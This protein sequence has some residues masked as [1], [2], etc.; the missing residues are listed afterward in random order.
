MKHTFHLI[1]PLCENQMRYPK[2]W[3]TNDLSSME[4]N[5]FLL[6]I[7]GGW[8]HAQIIKQ[9]PLK[10][11]LEPHSI[12]SSCHWVGDK[13]SLPDE[14][15][16]PP[17]LPQ[18]LLPSEKDESDLKAALNF[19][20]QT[21]ANFLNSATLFGHGLIGGRLDHQL[22]VLGE[23]SLWLDE[24]DDQKKKPT[25]HLL[26]QEGKNIITI[27]A[28]LYKESRYHGG[29]SLFSLAPQQVKLKGGLKYLGESIKLTPLSSRGLSNEALGPYEIEGE[30]ALILK[31][32]S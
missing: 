18:I 23:L 3:Q 15:P 10:S 19:L 13:D 30:K 17:D 2:Y 5:A 27:F 28:G 11:L 4:R 25:I 6:F 29:L 14:L 12:K 16:L 31:R 24:L 26:D 9:G 21:R 1:G 32:F 20:S 7:D 8:R 22:A